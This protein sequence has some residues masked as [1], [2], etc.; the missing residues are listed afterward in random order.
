M[1]LFAPLLILTAACAS[2]QSAFLVTNL[3]PSGT[4]SLRQAIE[5]ANANADASV[6]TFSNGSGGSIDFHDPATPKVIPLGGSELLVSQPLEL[7]GPGRDLL[8]L[9]GGSDG[10]STVEAGETRV[11]RIENTTGA[12]KVVTLRGLTVR[13]GIQGVSSGGGGISSTESLTLA[14]CRVTSCIVTGFNTLGGGGILSRDGTLRLERCRIDGNRVD[15]EGNGGGIYANAATLLMF[16]SE[17]SD[18]VVGGIFSQAGGIMLTFRAGTIE[19]C[20]ILRNR[21]TGNFG[22]GGGVLVGSSTLLRMTDTVIDSNS[23]RGGGGG[24]M[25]FTNGTSELRRCTISR[26]TTELDGG[27][28]GGLAL[29]TEGCLL[30]QCTISDNAVRGTTAEGGACFTGSGTAGRGNVTF[31]HCTIAGNS[32]AAGR[33]AGVVKAGQIASTVSFGH[34]LVA[35]NSGADFKLS[36]T[37]TNNGFTSRGWNVVGSGDT[38]AFILSGDRRGVAD[39]GL[40]PLA[41]NGGLVPTREVLPDSPAVSAGNPAFVPPGGSS[42]LQFDQRGS[43]FPRVVNRIE[44]GAFEIQNKPPVAVADGPYRVAEDGRLVVPAATGVL[45]NDTDP[46][47]FGGVENLTARLVSAPAHGLLTFADDGS[48]VYTPSKDFFGGDSFTYLAADRQLSNN[49]SAPATVRL[50]VEEESDVAVAVTPLR[51]S[52]ISGAPAREA[53]RVTVTNRGPSRVTGLRLAETASSDAGSLLVTGRSASAGD[54]DSS[55]GLWNLELAEGASAELRIEGRI[56]GVTAAGANASYRMTVVSAGQPLIVPLEDDTAQ[57]SLPVV[58]P[59]AIRVTTTGLATRRQTG[60]VTGRLTLANLNL[61]DVPALR[62]YVTGLPAGARVHNATGSAAVGDPPVLLP[63]LEFNQTLAASTGEVT[64]TIE[65]YDPMRRTTLSPGYLVEILPERTSRPPIQ[66]AGFAVRG[67]FPQPDGGQLI[68]WNAEFG[69]RYAVQYS[70]DM[71]TWHQVEPAVTAPAN[72]VQ[73]VDD[74]PPKTASH[75]RSAPRRYYRILE[76][77]AED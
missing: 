68:E 8:A 58:T 1:K 51:E 11:F 33:G 65:V 19:R 73:W 67:P 47:T 38:A 28:G 41:D 27:N 64:L 44:A 15:G 24:G 9:S 22:G 61:A 3:N 40:A 14:D 75:P 31:S 55:P 35:G 29:G 5:S 2:A 39:P 57:A 12:A 50:V 56:T 66:D 16:D 34:C 13:D 48:F 69:R 72:R 46:E 43:G 10:D 18:N 23:V 63:Y 17:V 21:T 70:N 59:G 4:G 76:L 60:L 37:G 74:G 62:V 36:D 77:P 45:V 42:L 54:V 7:V 49:L 71:T 25:L 6:I 53:F 26:N 32:A 30:E 52:L 20:R